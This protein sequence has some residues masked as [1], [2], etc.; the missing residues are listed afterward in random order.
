MQCNYYQILAQNCLSPDGAAGYCINFRKCNFIV[1]LII[2]LQQK[3]DDAVL[4]YLKKS[5]CG[6][7][8]QD[9]MVTMILVFIIFREKKIASIFQ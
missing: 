1:N 3:Q 7:D 6:Q 8:G 4:N 9:P 5:I 2:Q